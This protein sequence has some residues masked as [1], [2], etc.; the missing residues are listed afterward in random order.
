MRRGLWC[1]CRSSHA[2][3]GVLS[4]DSRQR[5]RSRARTT[6]IAARDALREFKHLTRGHTQQRCDGLFAANTRMTDSRRSL[7]F[8][9]RDDLASPNT[10]GLRSVFA[11]A[12][13]RASRKIYRKR[14]DTAGNNCSAKARVRNDGSSRARI[15]AMHS[16]RAFA[17][18][19]CTSFT[20]WQRARCIQAQQVQL[21]RSCRG[22]P[23]DANHYSN[24]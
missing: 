14:S 3:E 17:T 21:I 13:T 11:A 2:D 18:L 5:R 7:R 1:G 16:R 19:I 6:R 10:R 12:R 15:A 23:A 4:V 20:M 24:D 9:W 8:S 22:L